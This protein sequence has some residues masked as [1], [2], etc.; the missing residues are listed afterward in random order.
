MTN[1]NKMMYFEDAKIEFFGVPLAYFP[2]FSAPDPTVKRKSGFL[3]PIVSTSSAYGFGIETPYYFALAPNYDLTFSPRKFTT[4]QGPLLQGR[5]PRSAS[6]TALHHSARPASTSSTRTI[7]SATTA[8]T[9]PGYPRLARQHRIL[10]T[11]RPVAAMDLGMGLRPGFRR[12]PTSRTTRSSRCSRD[13]PIRSSTPDWTSCQ[14]LYLTGRGDRSYFDIRGDSLLRLFRSSTCRATLPVVLPVIDYDYTF[15]Q[16]VFGGEL[17]YKH[18]TSPT[19]RAQT[20]SYDADFGL[21]AGQRHYAPSIRRTP[22]QKVSTNCLLRGIPGNLLRALSSEVEWRRQFIDPLGQ[23]L[24]PFVLVARRRGRGLRST[25]SP[26]S[27]T[28]LT[29]GDT[30]RRRG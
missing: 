10:G 28:I 29:P 11:F 15:D 14:Q 1:P 25:I 5:V 21:N 19:C 22:P 16:P 24:M 13:P 4:K 30:D 20:A 17:S 26:A 2:Y 6:R 23:V 9:T 18:R 7:S 12:R 27:R 8:S 3:M